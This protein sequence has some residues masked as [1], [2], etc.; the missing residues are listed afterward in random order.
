MVVWGLAASLVMLQPR[1]QIQTLTLF[2]EL[3]LENARSLKNHA[4]R[5]WNHSNHYGTGLHPGH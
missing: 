3:R 5:A 4:S 2:F 1:V